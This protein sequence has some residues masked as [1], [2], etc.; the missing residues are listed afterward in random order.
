MAQRGD[1]LPMVTWLVGMSWS[2][3]SRGNQACAQAPD[4]DLKGWQIWSRVQ[5]W[6]TACFFFSY[7]LPAKDG[8]Y[9]RPFATDLMKGNAN[10]ELQ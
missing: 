3:A 9:R 5:V 1:N 2:M 7:S 10:F 6:L 8:F 4:R